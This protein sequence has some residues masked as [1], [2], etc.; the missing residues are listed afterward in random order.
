M[1][2]AMMRDVSEEETV[3]Q[4][5]NV[6]DKDGDGLISA[7]E[8]RQTMMGLGEEVKMIV[9]KIFFF[10][11][12]EVSETEVTAMVKEADLNGDGFIDFIEFSKL[13]K[14]NFGLNKQNSGDLGPPAC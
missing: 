3:R 10:L 11:F 12:F 7:E 5:F 2:K 4:A 6:F 8:I 14:I 13:M 1:M 9:D